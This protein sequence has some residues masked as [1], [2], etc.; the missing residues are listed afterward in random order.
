MKRYADIY[1]DA[2]VP[3]DS[4]ALRDDGAFT[5]CYGQDLLRWQLGAYLYDW[6]P[7]TL[8]LDRCGGR[9]GRVEWEEPDDACEPSP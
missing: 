7:L 8:R 1:E 3:G 6:C 5:A 4:I 2:D 9:L